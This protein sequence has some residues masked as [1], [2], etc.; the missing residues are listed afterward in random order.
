M[1]LFAVLWCFSAKAAIT[2]DSVLN[3][4]TVG[5]GYVSDVNHILSNDAV[6]QINEILKKLDTAKTAQIAV[7]VV[8]TIGGKVP[9]EFATELFKS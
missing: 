1:L 8:N 2:V 3:P 5:K 4:K 7:V 9:K 6:D